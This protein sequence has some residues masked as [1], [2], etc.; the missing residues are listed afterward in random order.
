[1]PMITDAQL[2]N[3]ASTIQNLESKV[4]ENK[5]RTEQQKNEKKELRQKYEHFLMSM[6]GAGG[7][8]LT[9]YLHR[10]EDAEGNLFFPRTTIPA[11][12]TLGVVGVG[13]GFFCA[14]HAK[15]NSENEKIGEG[16]F[17]LSKGVLWGSLAMY[18]RKHALAGK[19]IDKLWGGAPE[20]M[21]PA[22][23]NYPSIGAAP[24]RSEMTDSDL[25]HALRRAL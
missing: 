11:D 8:A 16:V 3:L 21:G 5:E 15:K 22:S 10:Y 23:H 9:G 24:V 19:R 25:A 18:F 17:E 14:L 20:L 12:L 2:N 13:A 7:A 4:E 1:M 6:L